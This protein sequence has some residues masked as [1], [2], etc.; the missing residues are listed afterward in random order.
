MVLSTIGNDKFPKARV[1]LL[2]QF[3]LKGFIFFSNYK[4][5]KGISIYKNNNVSLLFYWPSQERQIIIKG[6]V[7]KTS[8]SFSDDYFSKR[9]FKSQVSAFLSNQSEIIDSYSKLKKDM[10]IFLKENKN[11]RIKRPKNWG[12]YIVKPFEFE[13][14]QGRPNRLHQRVLFSF[15]KTKKWKINILSP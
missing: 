15:L 10:D 13:F 12:G 9:P 1:V 7:N 14:W 5:E 4:S 3:D 2:K 11:K 6:T 8:S